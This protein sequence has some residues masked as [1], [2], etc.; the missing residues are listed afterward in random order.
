MPNNYNK[1]RK[2]DA[3]AK[4]TTLSKPTKRGADAQKWV[5]KERKQWARR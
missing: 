3:L 1:S 5:A 4:L 2:L